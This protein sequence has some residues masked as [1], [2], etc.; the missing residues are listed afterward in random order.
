MQK[1]VR[2]I[3]WPYHD[4]LHDIKAYHRMLKT[5]IEEDRFPLDKQLSDICQTDWAAVKENFH[6]NF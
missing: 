1:A 4:R 3:H 6:K 5:R 2:D